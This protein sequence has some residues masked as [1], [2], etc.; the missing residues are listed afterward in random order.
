MKLALMKGIWPCLHRHLTRPF[1]P[2]SRPG[3]IR[4]PTYVVCLDCG[5][6]FGY[7]LDRMRVGKAIRQ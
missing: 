7:D 1:T 3:G 5:R 2:L 4:K 6:Q